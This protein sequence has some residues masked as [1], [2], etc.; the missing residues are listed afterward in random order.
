MVALGA[1][2]KG[3]FTLG[4]L[5]EALRGMPRDARMLIRLPDGQ[6][7][8]IDHV[9]A[10]HVTGGNAGIGSAL[11]TVGAEV[12]RMNPHLQLQAEFFDHAAVPP[13]I[14]E[15][16]D[17]WPDIDPCTARLVRVAVMSYDPR[18]RRQAWEMLNARAEL[19]L[20]L[21]SY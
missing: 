8:E 13:Q 6:L 7:V 19:A 5:A 1:H 14:K 17:E 21:R 12:I 4:K 16:L 9:T 10:A 3:G 20:M 18:Q 11:A 15:L 2:M